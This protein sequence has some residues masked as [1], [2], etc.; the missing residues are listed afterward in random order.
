MDWLPESMP[1]GEVEWGK[2]PQLG[3]SGETSLRE[4]LEA[5]ARESPFPSSFERRHCLLG[6]SVNTSVLICLSDQTGAKTLHDLKIRFRHDPSVTVIQVAN[7]F[8]RSMLNADVAT[9]QQK[10]PK[11]DNMAALLAEVEHIDINHESNDAKSANAAGWDQNTPLIIKLVQCILTEALVKNASDIHL[12]PAA[13]RTVSVRIRQHGLMT[14]LLAYPLSQHPAVI[15]RVKIL[16]Q[17]DISEKRVPQ[18]GKFQFFNE[19]KQHEARVATLPTIYGESAVIRLLGD[20]YV[21]TLDAADWH[22]KA[23]QLVR[24]ILQQK[25]G[26]LLVVG[27]TG[28][29]KTS[30]LHSLLKTFKQSGKKLWTVEDPVEV[31]QPHLQQ[32]QINNKVNLTFPKVLRSLLRADP[33]IILIGELRDSETAEVALQAAVTG[34]LVLSTL[35]TNSA[36]GAITRLRDLGI[37]NYQIDDALI[38]VISQRLVLQRCA[39]TQILST[40]SGFKP[41]C[42]LCNG[43]GHIGRVA[44][45]EVLSLCASSDNLPSSTIDESQQVP[46]ESYHSFEDDLAWKRI[47]RSPNTSH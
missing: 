33:D 24:T 39:C 16:A 45:H 29:G 12:E 34:H 5:G 7:K 3:E 46:A 35:H 27:P 41:A 38:G 47:D 2:I 15:A 8:I 13:M 22:P 43:S 1:L 37:K 28:S 42:S 4:G 9:T 19:Q 14:T 23:L 25:Q 36:I 40:N 11:P 10:P 21:R 31:T 17:L 30:T 32:V 18:D 6:V 44:V 20:G 26:L